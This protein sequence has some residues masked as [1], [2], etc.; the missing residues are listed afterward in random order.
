MLVPAVFVV[1][2]NEMDSTGSLGLQIP[3]NYK[4]G[5]ITR[6]LLWFD[7]VQ[8]H[9][10][11]EVSTGSMI[12]LLLFHINNIILWTDSRGYL[13]Q[14]RRTLDRIQDHDSR[15][16]DTDAYRRAMTEH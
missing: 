7:G 6:F 1:C 16:K 10:C 12:I 4:A 15:I 5:C 11:A 8:G 3:W 2:Q 14:T 13:L 9:A